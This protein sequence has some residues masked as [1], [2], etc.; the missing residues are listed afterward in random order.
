MALFVGNYAEA[1]EVRKNIPVTKHLS[2]ALDKAKKSSIPNLKEHH[3]SSFKMAQLLSK[4]VTLEEQNSVAQAHYDELKHILESNGV[5]VH[6][7]PAATRYMTPEDL[8]HKRL[9][10]ESF[11][12]DMD[13]EDADMGRV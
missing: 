11:K 1:D 4:L 6:T 7:T 3:K 10:E 8:E 13:V 2:E 9:R 12:L 5:S